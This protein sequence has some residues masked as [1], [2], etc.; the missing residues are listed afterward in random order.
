MCVAFQF[1]WVG[2]IVKMAATGFACVCAEEV[3]SAH[4]HVTYFT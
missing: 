4:M 3:G 1:D 2:V